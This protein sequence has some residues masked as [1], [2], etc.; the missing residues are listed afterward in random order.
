MRRERQKG[1]AFQS[2]FLRRIRPEH[3][4]LV[5]QVTGFMGEGS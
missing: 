4:S 1:E 3:H 5:V 2:T